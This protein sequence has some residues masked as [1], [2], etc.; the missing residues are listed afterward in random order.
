MPMASETEMTDGGCEWE[1]SN[2]GVRVLAAGLRGTG[3]GSTQ[4]GE[5]RGWCISGPSKEGGCG[6]RKQR[7]RAGNVTCICMYSL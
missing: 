3:V 2:C 6:K 5:G 1:P 7:G 4:T